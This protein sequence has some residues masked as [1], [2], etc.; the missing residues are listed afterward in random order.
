MAPLAASVALTALVFVAITTGLLVADLERPERFWYIL[1]RPQWRSWLTRGTYILI[2][3]TVLV[4]LWAALEAATGLATAVAG[5]PAPAAGST[6]EPVGGWATLQRALLALIAV[7]GVA[8][9]GYTAFLFGQAEGRDLWQSRLLALHLVIQALMAGAAALA[10]LLLVYLT[11]VTAPAGAADA[12]LAMLKA[13][14][15]LFGISAAANLALSVAEVSR[16]HDSASAAAAAWEIRS[17]RHSRRFWW[18]AIVGGHVVPLA[19]L[20]GT[21]LALTIGGSDG[22]IWLT[23]ASAAA[24]A[25]A[26][27]FFYE[28]VFVAAPQEIPNS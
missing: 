14:A 22:V 4:L 15:G 8:A 6:V 1:R 3:Y 19:L 21:L 16:R 12:A 10:V 2:G 27:L 11:T 20:A 28:Q 24:L 25:I 18:G 5:G 17:G 23:L 7:G 13:G 9:A 26:G